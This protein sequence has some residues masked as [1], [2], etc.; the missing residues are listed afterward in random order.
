MREIVDRP[1]NRK[2]LYGLGTATCLTL[3]LV[4]FVWIPLP[5]MGVRDY[6][7]SLAINMSAGMKEE[8]SRDIE[9]ILSRDPDNLYAHLM[10]AYLHYE[11][12]EWEKAYE[13]YKRSLE[14]C[15]AVPDSSNKKSQI[16]DGLLDTLSRLSL[17]VNCYEDAKH[18]AEER[19][20]LFGENVSSKL[21]I[22]LSCFLLKDDKSFEENLDRAV[23]MGI[24]DPAFRMKL[25]SLIENRE[26][27][28]DLYLRSLVERAKYE[29]RLTG[30]A[31]L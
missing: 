25:D 16:I 6:E 12:E 26:L 22:A 2:M 9:K 27:L 20:R 31:S 11:S 13:V 28:N 8:S 30:R 5:E 3:V 21:I 19:I 23:E 29:Q 17:K 7:A 14:C 24:F 1:H 18:Y 10:K 15:K 4:G